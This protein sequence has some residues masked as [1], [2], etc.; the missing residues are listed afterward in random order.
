MFTD[1]TTMATKNITT[2]VAGKETQASSDQMLAIKNEY[3]DDDLYL[4]V[5]DNPNDTENFSKQL[6]FKDDYLNVKSEEKGEIAETTSKNLQI[7]NVCVN[8]NTNKKPLKPSIKPL[9]EEYVFMEHDFEHSLD[10]FCITNKNGQNNLLTVIKKEQKIE[11]Y[12]EDLK[13][14]ETL[15]IHYNTLQDSGFIDEDDSVTIKNYA[16]IVKTH[17]HTPIKLVKH[18][19]FITQTVPFTVTSHKPSNKAD[20]N[21]QDNMQ[22]I[23]DQNLFKIITE[24]QTILLEDDAIVQQLID[25]GQL[26]MNDQEEAQEV[27]LYDG[28]DPQFQNNQES[29]DIILYD[30]IVP[31]FHNN[32][33]DIQEIT[34]CDGD[35]AHFQKNI[36]KE[37][38]EIILYDSDEPQFQVDAIEEFEIISE[39]AEDGIVLQQAVDTYICNC[40]EQFLNL[41][42]LAKHD[43]IHKD[44]QNEVNTFSHDCRKILQDQKKNKKHQ[45]KPYGY[46]IDDIIPANAVQA[47][48]CNCGNLFQNLGEFKKHQHDEK[49]V[50]NLQ[51]NICQIGVKSVKALKTHMQSH[52]VVCLPRSRAG[53]INSVNKQIPFK[54]SHGGLFSCNICNKTYTSRIVLRKH[55]LIHSGEKKFACDICGKGFLQKITLLNHKFIHVNPVTCSH[56][57]IIFKGKETFECHKVHGVCPK[58]SKKELI[59]TFKEE[60][61]EN[62]NFIG[63]NCLLC[64][65]MTEEECLLED[66]MK[67]KHFIDSSELIC[68]ECGVQASSKAEL[69]K[70]VKCHDK[71]RHYKPIPCKYCDRAFH[72]QARLLIHDRVHTNERPFPCDLCTNTFKTKTHLRTHYLTH[73]KVKNFICSICFKAFALNGN[74][75]LHLR[76]HTK[77]KP[78]VCPLCKAAYLDSKHLKKHKLAVHPE[79]DIPWQEYLNSSLTRSGWLASAK[80]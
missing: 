58:K 9:K 49:A 11:D 3:D 10:T 26:I 29:K 63:Y 59:D 54:K 61:I 66:H 67:T 64:N 52:N 5:V 28:D 8:A 17:S 74:L 4:L 77:E 40:G 15:Y 41:E 65:E 62:N 21:S 44:E 79:S 6:T 46:P 55:K 78:Y 24:D 51:C 71:R 30:G 56:C 7:N 22:E 48:I 18:D 14:H 25:S 36:K 12:A 43:V 76:T 16:G 68:F 35:E 19:A 27:I 47:F 70:H 20:E 50:E 45:A 75:V 39:V 80:V 1:L 73:T 38:Q 72:S 60:V 69:Q 31:Q 34:L 32:R 23:T 53:K 13:K 2:I 33:E 42:E 37:T 57:D